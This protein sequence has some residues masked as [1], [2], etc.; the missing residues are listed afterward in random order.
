M[1]T[2]QE[3][4]RLMERPDS[5]RPVLSLFLDMSVG[6]DNHR[7]HAVFVAQ[8]RGRAGELADRGRGVRREAL[9]EAID[10]AAGWLADGFEPE[11]RGVAVFVEV[12]GGWLEAVQVPV[13][14]P[15]LLCLGRRP[16]L[17]PLVRALQGRRRHALVLVDRAHLRMLHVWLGRVV[18]EEEVRKDPYPAAH[19]VQGGGF[20]EQRYQR[21]KLEEERHFFTDFAAAAAAFVARTGA[22]D[23]VLLGT[24][25]NVGKFRRFLP[26]SVEGRVVRTES[27]R[28][29]APAS[30]VLERLSATLDAEDAEGAE[31]VARLRERVAAG[32]Y[33]A[34]GVQPTL[35]ALQAGSVEAVLLADDRADGGWRCTR[36]SFLF[37]DEVE[38]CPYD[39]APVENGVAVVEEAIRLAAAQGARTRLV[40]PAVAGEFDGAGA[41]LRF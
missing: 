33:A 22:D 39:G 13:P 20:A 4:A 19:D 23:V 34:S 3:I 8:Q 36:C 17:A 10:R 35:S 31:L 14:L 5:G 16:A 40:P 24:T 1:I 32:Y 6:P 37:A 18:D 38:A 25:E 7:T 28:A 30:E 12:G 11:N 21:H 27:V 26:E 15:N 2:R 41:L 29:D 9:E